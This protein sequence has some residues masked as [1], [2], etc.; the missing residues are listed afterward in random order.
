[1][2][3]N[4]RRPIEVAVIGGGMASIAAAFELSR[5]RHRNRF[6]VTIYQQGWRLG[7]KAASC[8]G[9]AGRIEEHGLHVWHGFYENAFR[10]LRECYQE[11]DRDPRT[12]RFASWRDAFFTDPG[13]VTMEETPG[14]KRSPWAIEYPLTPGEPGDPIDRNNP[15]C[16]LRYLVQAANLAGGLLRSLD[17]GS[18]SR[19]NRQSPRAGRRQLPAEKILE[20]INRLI[21]F[22]TLASVADLI[23]AA[24]LLQSALGSLSGGRAN[25]LSKLVD[26]MRRSARESVSRMT[27]SDPEL[28][29]LWALLDLTLTSILGT[30]RDLLTDSRGFDAVD[31][32]DFREWLEVNGASAEARD[33]PIVRSLYD[34][35]F[36]YEDGDP[37]RPRLG[38][39]Q[40]LRVIARM[41]FSYRG[42]FFWKMRAGMGETVITPFYEVLKRRGVSFRFF[43]RLDKVRLAP[44]RKLSAGERPYIEALD[45]EVQ[46]RVKDRAEYDPLE[47]VNGLRCWRAEPD[48]KQLVGGASLRQAGR[49]FESH[50]DAPKGRKRISR[51]KVVEDFDFVVLGVSLGAIPHVAAEILDRDERWRE[52]VG[53]VKTVATQA[54]QVWIREDIEELGWRSESASVV[55]V[56]DDFSAWVDMSH[57]LGEE[58]WPERPKALAYFCSALPTPDGIPDRAATSYPGS[59]HKRVCGN[60]VR[61][62]DREVS[63]IWPRAASP[64]DGFRWDLLVDW[65]GT[66]QRGRSRASALDGQYCRANVNPSDRYVLSLPGSQRH[67]ISPLDNTYDNMTIAG[68]WTDC[69][70]N[71]GS[72]ESAVMSGLLAAHALCGSPEL[73]EIVGFDHP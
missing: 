73:R 25:I 70:F 46:A 62:L 27:D 71:I 55:G 64:D 56:A 15:F 35:C 69:G 40:A 36:A 14:G 43:H 42:A 45:F 13:A 11:L 26:V 4:R 38:A 6:H 59:E 50:W 21:R 34:L 9:P 49:D 7:G 67:R 54:L 61:F 39:G 33:S 31:H 1:M 3:S 47:V 5:P 72:I 57:L 60:A 19:K 44:E 37:R 53:N 8:R 29:R 16:I 23:L 32:Y 52:M 68:D 22:G 10:I 17:E 18:R 65:R 58:N 2:S 41:F 48:W 12:D 63:R 51:L 20:G 24:D 30:L 66:R 28:R